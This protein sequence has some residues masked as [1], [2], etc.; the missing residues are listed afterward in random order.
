MNLAYKSIRSFWQRYGSKHCFRKFNEFLFDC[1]VH[2]LGV[3][4][5][6]NTGL[7]GELHFI[8]KILPRLVSEKK[9]VFIDV[10]S[11]VGG[12][13]LALLDRFPE[14]R[15]LACEPN[16]K[17]FAKLGERVAERN[18]EI[19]NFGLGAESEKVTFYDRVDKG[20]AS[21]HG[22][23]YREVIE[24]HHRTESVSIE[25]ELRT[26]DE[27]LQEKGIQHVHFVKID[28]EGH[29]LEV[30]KGASASIAS[31][32]VDIFQI[33]FNEMNIVSKVFYQDI[34]DLLHDYVGYRLLPHGVYKI[35]A[36]PIRRELFGFQNII[37]VHKRFNADNKLRPQI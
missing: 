33:E 37:F 20:G 10:G 6:D 4:N 12:Y 11:N 27:L 30:L 31:G 16:P 19:L 5:H 7:S 36:C 1:A 9:P 34:A 24:D 8:N 13:S 2:G 32:V 18:V 26:L 21:S 14:G 3:G 25:V 17:V 22:S 23:L 29:E 15:I 28:T 35:R